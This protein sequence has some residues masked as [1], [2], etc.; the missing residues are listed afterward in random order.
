MP[1]AKA[2]K[3]WAVSSILIAVA[4]TLIASGCV[5][6]PIPST[7][8]APYEGAIDGL[9]TGITRKDAVIEQFGDP[10]GI[11]ARGSE[12]IYS[13]TAEKWKI[14]Y[15]SLLGHAGGVET[16]DKRFVLLISFDDRDILSGFH[17]ETAGA[18]VG[19]CTKTGICFGESGAVMRFADVVDE[20]HAKTF[21]VSNQ[22]CSIYLYGPGNKNAN[23]VN[24]N[25]STAVNFLSTRTF[26]QWLAEPGMQKVMVSPGNTFLQFDCQAGEIVF[27]H[28][29]YHWSASS[30]LLL[31]DYATGREHVM[32]SRLVLL[33]TGSIGPPLPPPLFHGLQDKQ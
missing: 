10:D 25:S 5:V 15:A 26:I 23:R 22:Q 6:I 20:N 2:L 18:D 4:C 24:L 27:V 11:Y 32:N 28:F 21:P 30:K 17:V 8:E 7:Q 12:F 33:P 19:D 3:Q 31:E 9:E 14:F 16:V 13:E 29:D 1:I